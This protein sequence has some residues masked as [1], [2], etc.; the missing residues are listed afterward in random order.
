M[1]PVHPIVNGGSNSSG[2]KTE[3]RKM[4]GMVMMMVMVMVFD[5]RKSI[6]AY[7]SS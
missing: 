1:V 7:S 4:L 3:F 2:T 5:F 6:G